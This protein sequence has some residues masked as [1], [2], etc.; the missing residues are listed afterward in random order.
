MTTTERDARRHR[1]AALHTA[2]VAVAFVSGTFALMAM[3]LGSPLQFGIALA[4]CGVGWIVTHFVERLA[5]Q[6]LS[7]R[8]RHV[9]AAD[10]VHG[11]VRFSALVQSQRHPGYH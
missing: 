9:G 6:E 11:Y 5:E 8:R 3:L 2:A 4:L 10:L 7:V 1:Y